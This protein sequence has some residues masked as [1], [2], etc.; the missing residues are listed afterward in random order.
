VEH[1]GEQDEGDHGNG[2]LAS[3][4]RSE[5]YET[6]RAHRDGYDSVGRLAARAAVSPATM[7]RLSRRLGYTGYAALKLAIAQEAGRADQFG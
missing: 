3:G 6:R 5:V 1:P 7:V 2:E 4:H